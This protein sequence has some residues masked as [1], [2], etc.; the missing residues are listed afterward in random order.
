M[1]A[2]LT[3]SILA[4]AALP[5]Q[6][7]EDGRGQSLF[8]ATW[9]SE[10][11]E[12][13]LDFLADSEPGIVVLRGK[14]TSDDYKEFRQDNNFWYFTGITTPNAVLVMTTDTRAQYLLVPAVGGNDERWMGNLIDPEEASELTGI[15]KTLAIDPRGVALK[16]LLEELLV[17]REKF[18]IQ[19]R[20]AEN[21]MMSRDNLSSW[22]RS[23][24]GDGYDGRLSR[25]AQFAERLEKVHGVKVA[26]MT[27][28]IDG[29]R[30]IKTP[31]EV[32]AM[33]RACRA[34]GE[35][36]KAVMRTAM[37]GDYEWQLA[38]RMTYEFQMAGGMGLGAYAAI[39]TSGINACTFHYNENS[40]Q[41]EEEEL[42]MIDY[43]AE[44]NHFVADIS[45]TWPTGKKFTKRQREVYE[46]VFA[47]QEAA[48]K[49]CKPGGN[50]RKVDAAAQ[51]VLTERGFG[52]MW[53]GTCHWLGMSTHDVGRY[54]N[55]V[56]EPGMTFTVEP[57]IYLPKENMGVR[58]ED[59]VVITEDGYE[60]ISSMIPRDIDAIEALRKEAYSAQNK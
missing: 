55:Y 13:L 17:G 24:K 15:E 32:E 9:H 42:V 40:R 45:R 2:L 1:L 58:I 38:A 27:V 29:M 56:F 10:R 52:R 7:P 43:G 6:S 49:E 41:L 48:F 46:A 5:Q 39:V 28:S 60:L 37:P 11:R 18:Y 23:I 21:W 59:V 47:A 34:S 26:D 54:T 25:E 31:E 51:K 16:K 20:P 53:H 33:R 30:V 19:K 36:H 22:E 44:Y 57:G 14:G 8:D 3:T 35:G 12:A 4:F 50:L